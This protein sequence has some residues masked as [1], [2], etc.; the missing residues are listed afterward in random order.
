MGCCKK[1]K[2]NKKTKIQKDMIKAGKTNKVKNK[3]NSV[4]DESHSIKTK[5]Y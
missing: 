2:E 5:C 1:E 4:N 3:I